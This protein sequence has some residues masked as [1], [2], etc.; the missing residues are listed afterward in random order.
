MERSKMANRIYDATP[1]PPPKPNVSGS[2]SYNANPYQGVGGGSGGGFSGAGTSSI[3]G[4]YSPS[5]SIQG[6]YSPAS[7]STQQQSINNTKTSQATGA[8]QSSS[9][10]STPPAAP[11]N[12]ASAP[13]PAPAPAMETITIPDAK[14]DPVYQQQVA[15]LAQALTDFQAQQQLAR[16]QYQGGYDQTLRGLGY[17]PNGF[18]PR[19]QGSYGQDYQSNEGDF[20][21]RGAFYSGIYGQSVADLNNAYNQQKTGLDTARQNY[22]DAQNLAGTQYGNQNNLSQQAALNDAIA[23]IAAQYGVDLN[24][25]PTGTGSSTITRPVGP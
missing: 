17:G 16:T 2:G 20:A 23:R 3:E 1:P 9:Q 10:T 15:S 6:Q 7:T 11:T 13:A 4:Y 8:N 19:G 14:V 22:L 21:G 24:Q 25:V 18:D 5:Y 12:D